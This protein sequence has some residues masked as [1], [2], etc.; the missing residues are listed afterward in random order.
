MHKNGPGEVCAKKNLILICCTLIKI[1]SEG[2]EVK[3][4]EDLPQQA[5]QANEWHEGEAQVKTEDDKYM[6][7]N[8]KRSYDESRGY[9]YYEH[10]DDRR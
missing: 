1:V 9:G 10:R 6:S 4:E 2:Y 7:Y 5:E 8:R 3:T